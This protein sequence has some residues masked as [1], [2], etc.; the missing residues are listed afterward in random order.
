MIAAAYHSEVGF[1][2]A[3]KN[4]L[5]NPTQPMMGREMGQVCQPIVGY[6]LAWVTHAGLWVTQWV[7]NNAN[8]RETHDCIFYAVLACIFGY[9]PYIELFV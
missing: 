1:A 3:H 5:P 2:M 8:R 4:P 6:G 7:S 9:F